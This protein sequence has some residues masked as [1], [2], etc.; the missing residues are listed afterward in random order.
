M[1]VDFYELCC[2]RAAPRIFTG[3]PDLLDGRPA[4]KVG[5]PISLREQKFFTAFLE[6]F[7]KISESV[8]MRG[9]T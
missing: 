5:V 4:S 8:E 6:I 9:R 7:T 1:L 2:C 3:G